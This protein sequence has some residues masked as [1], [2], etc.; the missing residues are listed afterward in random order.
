MVLKWLTYTVISCSLISFDLSLW[1]PV[2]TDPAGLVCS[3]A[4]GV[5][6]ETQCGGNVCYRDRSSF[7]VLQPHT[8]TQACRLLHAGECVCVWCVWSEMEKLLWVCALLCLCVLQVLLQVLI[9]LSG[10]YNFFNIL[11]IT[12][13]LSLL[14]D[15][16]VNFWLRRPTQKTESSM[17]K[18]TLD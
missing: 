1:D 7:P 10:N 4:A 12:L 14:D 8:K 15:Q 6:P 5:V 9:I 3:S 11:T 16:H 2:Y 17:D 13:C 18:L